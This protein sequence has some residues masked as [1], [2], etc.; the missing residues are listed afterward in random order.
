[1]QRQPSLPADPYRAVAVT[2]AGDHAFH[3]GQPVTTAVDPP[4]GAPARAAWGRLP[5]AAGAGRR[6]GV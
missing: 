3:N 2:S 5:G 4:R 6:G 1:V